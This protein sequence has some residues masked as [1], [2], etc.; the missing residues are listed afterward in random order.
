MLIIKKNISVEKLH[1]RLQKPAV[2]LAKIS[3]NGFTHQHHQQVGVMTSAQL[4]N[5]RTNCYAQ[6]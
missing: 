6:G 4:H 3:I 5:I 2:L 1:S